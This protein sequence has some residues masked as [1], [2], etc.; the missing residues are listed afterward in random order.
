MVNA[1]QAD[2]VRVQGQRQSAGVELDALIEGDDE[3]GDAR[4]LVARQAGDIGV[5]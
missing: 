3:A 2:V 5:W 4:T 1:A